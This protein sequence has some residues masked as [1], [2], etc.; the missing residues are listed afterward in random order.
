MVVIQ[1]IKNV[2]NATLEKINAGS[3]LSCIRQDL[4]S[5]QLATGGNENPLKI[6]DLETRKIEFTAKSV[7]LSLLRSSVKNNKKYIGLY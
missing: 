7:S 2:K 3:N 5:D 4:T 1:P 6:W